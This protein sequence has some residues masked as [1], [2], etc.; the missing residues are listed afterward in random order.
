MEGTK[1]MG[2][3]EAGDVFKMAKELTGRFSRQFR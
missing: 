2:K 1:E 3:K